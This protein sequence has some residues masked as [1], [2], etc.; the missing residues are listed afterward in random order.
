MITECQ[1]QYETMMKEWEDTYPITPI[2]TTSQTFWKDTNKQCLVIP[3]NNS[4]K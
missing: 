3:L 4:L 2:E 1:T